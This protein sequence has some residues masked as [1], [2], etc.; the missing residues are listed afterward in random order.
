MNESSKESLVAWEANADFW[1]A[2]MGDESN[3]THR[4][5]VRP[6]TELLLNIQPNDFV[7]D[8]ACGN[9]NFAKRLA[10]CGA[11]VVA[12]DY[13][14]KMVEN[15]KNRQAAYQACIDFHVCDATNYD[16]MM[17]LRK[18]R[19]YNKV[20]SNMAVMDIT[21]IKPMFQAVYD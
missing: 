13:S 8:I 7:L 14:E 4:E 19:P 15:A 16:E 1:D 11:K 17:K 3:R 21:D 5:M 2:K 10:E 9:G 18:E 20:V 12:F 6:K